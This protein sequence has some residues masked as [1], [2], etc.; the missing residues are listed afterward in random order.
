MLSNLKRIVTSMLAVVLLLVAGFG[1][2]T[3]VRDTGAAGLDIEPLAAQPVAL[4]QN[5]EAGFMLLTEAEQTLA[6]IYQE[7]SPSVV[8]ISTS[9]SGSAASPFDDEIAGAGSGFV[10]DM[11][12][13]IMTNYHVVRNASEIEVN[14]LDGTITRAEV[15]GLDADS[16]LAVIRVDIPSDRLIPVRFG[17]TDELVIGQSVVAI[18]SPFGQRWTLTSGIISALDRTIQGLNNYRIGSAIQ[19]DAPINPGNS[20]GPLLNLR[21]EVIGVNSQIISQTRSSAGIGFAV[22]SDLVQRVAQELIEN[23]NVAYS[24]MGIVGGDISLQIIEALDLANNQRGMFVDSVDPGSPA[25]VAGMRSAE[26]SEDGDLM[27]ADIIVAIDGTEITG[28]PSLISYLA[29]FTRPDDTV[30]VTVLRDGEEIDLEMTL[31]RRPS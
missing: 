13:H 2:G 6:A 8:A 27:S 22:P 15:V 30:V 10:I 16:D 9:R 17:N 25:G 12:G 31:A 3:L 19:T 18:G 7:V 5:S 4:D 11:D 20:G 14:F 28:F 21:G 23:G 24:L 26:I 29:R 1:I